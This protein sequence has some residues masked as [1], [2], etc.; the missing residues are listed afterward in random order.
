[1]KFIPVSQI[2]KFESERF[3]CAELQSVVWVAMEV[4]AVDVVEAVEVDSGSDLHHGHTDAD[5]DVMSF[6]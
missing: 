5:P 3:C 2:S 1:M 6:S 4:V